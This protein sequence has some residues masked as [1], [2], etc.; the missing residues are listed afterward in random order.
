MANASVIC[1]DK[2]GALTANDMTVVAGSI[3]IHAKF[4]R[5]LEENSGR[6]N[7]G[8]RKSSDG[9]EEPAARK[10]KDDFSID[11]SNLNSILSPQLRTLINENIA[12]NSTAFEDKDP[13]SGETILIGSKTE[14]ALIKLTKELGWPAFQ[15]VRDTA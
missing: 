8:D 9:Q 2:T 10:H 1:T 5:G 7:A 3:G 15:E 13:S 14:T 6:T 4:V 12:V 11:Q